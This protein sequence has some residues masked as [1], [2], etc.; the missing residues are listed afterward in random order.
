MR[1]SR[2]AGLLR[3]GQNRLYSVPQ[4]SLLKLNETVEGVT[5]AVPFRMVSHN[6]QIS[7]KTTL[8]RKY[9]FPVAQKW[10]DNYET[11]TGNF[12]ANST[13]LTWLGG[14]Y[15]NYL[16]AA[17]KS[18][19]TGVA[20]P[21]GTYAYGVDNFTLKVFL[22]SGT[23]MGF[24]NTNMYVE[25]S[26]LSWYNNSGRRLQRLA[27]ETPVPA[28]LRSYIKPEP[29]AQVYATNASGDLATQTYN[30]AQYCS[31]AF[32]LPAS[33]LIS[34]DVDSEGCYVLV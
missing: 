34:N 4:G 28:L 23:E 10:Y 32:T 1:M 11:T 20:I 25:G 3:A 30:V 22:L 33:T 8:I 12:F 21:C 27:D 19:I 26:A 13:M 31:P 24:S 9:V 14:T 18:L 5:A 6:G 2:K 15:Y 16:D 17:V 7:G 29:F